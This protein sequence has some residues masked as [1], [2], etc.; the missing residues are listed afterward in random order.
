MNSMK[1]K[2]GPP[3]PR[4]RSTQSLEGGFESGNIPQP[5]KM[6]ESPHSD[7]PPARTVEHRITG[8]S[9]LRHMHPTNVEVERTRFLN[10]VLRQTPIFRYAD[11]E[12]TEELMTMYQELL[13]L[14]PTLL[15]VS[16][17]FTL[18][19]TLTLTIPTQCSASL[20]FSTICFLRYNTQSYVP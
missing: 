3:R 20:E 11:Q 9:A 19:L 15:G 10:P 17:V 5:T 2:P 16:T 12:R 7:T 4:V 6:K 18:T 8:S 14:H 13:I 1:T